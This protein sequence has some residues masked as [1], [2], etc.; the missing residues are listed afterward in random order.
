D[1]YQANPEAYLAEHP[2][3]LHD[4]LLKFTARN[5]DWKYD[6]LIAKLTP[7]PPGRSF[8]VGRNLFRA[9]NCVGCHKL[10]GE[11]HELGPDLAKME[12]SRHTIEH[13]LKAIVEPSVDIDEKYQAFNFLLDSGKTITGT[14]LEETP[15]QLKVLVDPLARRDPITIER[16]EI[17]EQ[18]KSPVSIMPAGLL[19]NLTEEEIID[20]VAYVYARGDEK[21]RLY[22]AGHQHHDH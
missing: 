20:L 13:I 9:A 22:H 10:N 14:I 12:A 21:N 17:E 6:E 16:D 4:E 11:G 8:E 1:Q 19:S 7:L 3:E 2:L 18:V 5:T 15:T